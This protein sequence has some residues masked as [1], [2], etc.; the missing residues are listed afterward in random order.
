[1]RIVGVQWNSPI[2]E[3]ENPAEA[4]RAFKDEIKRIRG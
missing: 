3:E 1:M 4:A 2:T